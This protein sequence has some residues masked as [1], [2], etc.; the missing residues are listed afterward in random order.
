MYSKSL[1]DTCSQ[2]ETTQDTIHNRYCDNLIHSERSLVRV[3]RVRALDFGRIQS[4]TSVHRG[5]LFDKILSGQVDTPYR[6][7]YALYELEPLER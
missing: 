7:I 6:C 5:S 3:K 4:Q 2:K 1:F